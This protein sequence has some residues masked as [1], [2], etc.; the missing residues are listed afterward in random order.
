[1]YFQTNFNVIIIAHSFDSR[2]VN[3]N[4]RGTITGH[5][6][7]SMQVRSIVKTWTCPSYTCT[8]PC[9]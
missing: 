5:Y 4:T 9:Y 7:L 2:D 3:V 8:A 6:E 1:M